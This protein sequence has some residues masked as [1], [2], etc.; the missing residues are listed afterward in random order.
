MTRAKEHLTLSYALTREDGTET[1]PSALVEDLDPRLVETLSIEKKENTNTL[2]FL[3]GGGQ[4]SL[5]TNGPSDDDLDILRKAFLAQGL[6]P[7][8]T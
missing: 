5:I 2:S 8:R 7:D 1:A 4:R 6:S 3:P